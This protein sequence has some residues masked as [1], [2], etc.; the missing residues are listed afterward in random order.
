[1]NNLRGSNFCAVTKLLLS[2]AMLL[3][4]VTLHAQINAVYVQSNISTPKGNTVIGF[5]NDGFGNLTPLPGSPYLTQGTG[6]AVP[7]GM[8]LTVQNDDDGQLIANAAGTYMFTVNGHN[9]TI[10]TFSINP[11]GSLTLVG[12]PVASGGSQPA[13]IALLEGALTNGNT[14][15]VVANK[16]SDPTQLNQKAPNIVSFTVTP[17]GQ[18]TPN[19]GS[20]TVFPS[21][22]SP[23]QVLVGQGKLVIVDELQATPSQLAVYRIHANG[24]FD[25]LSSISAPPNTTVFL[26]MVKSPVS[27]YIYAGLPEQSMIAA[28]SYDPTSGLMNMVSSASTPG[29]LPCWLGINPA[30]TRLYTGD[31]KSNSVSVFDISN[32]TA[33]KFLQQLILSNKVGNGQPLNVQIDPTGKFLYALTGVGLHAINVQSDGTLVEVATPTLLNVPTGTLPYGLAS[34]LK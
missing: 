14:L 7:D 13:S 19:T 22:T 24:S 17:S 30:G 34:L 28:Y 3:G 20:K 6:W 26:G 27:K 23:S 2:T 21:G 12:T 25:P 11:D 29:I 18:V 16:S 33:P 9:N 8:T 31:T 32:P 15:M 1:M 4:A 5:S 10:S